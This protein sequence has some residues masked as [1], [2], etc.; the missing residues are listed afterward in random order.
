[1]ESKVHKF[2]NYRTERVLRSYQG[3]DGKFCRRLDSSGFGEE[4]N[5]L[6]EVESIRKTTDQHQGTAAQKLT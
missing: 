5:E 6:A 1:M 3:G 4:Y 2:T